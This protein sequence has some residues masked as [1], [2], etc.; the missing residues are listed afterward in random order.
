MFRFRLRTLL[1]ALKCCFEGKVGGGYGSLFVG[2]ETF[3]NP[4]DGDYLAVLAFGFVEGLGLFHCDV[5]QYTYLCTAML[6]HDTTEGDTRPTI[7]AL[8]LEILDSAN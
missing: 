7:R 8:L 1:E 2:D 3:F 4:I 6:R 5:G